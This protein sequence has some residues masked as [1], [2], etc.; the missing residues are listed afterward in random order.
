[1][2]THPKKKKKGAKQGRP[3]AY[4]SKIGKTICEMMMGSE[5]ETMSLR[6]VVAKMGGSPS[7]GTVMRWLATSKDFQ[8]Q[9]ARACEMR[10]H[11]MA[12]ETIDIADRVPMLTVTKDFKNGNSETKMMIDMGGV[13]S[14]RL[15]VET[16]QWYA[17]VCAPKKYRPVAAGKGTLTDQLIDLGEELKQARERAGVR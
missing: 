14:N 13:A 1:M 8:E 12:D 16:R 9:Y 10:G 11:L 7:M 5:G 17:S 15:Q 4:T 3:T 2:A 6:S